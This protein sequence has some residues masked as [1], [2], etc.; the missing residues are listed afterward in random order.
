MSL[1][2]TEAEY[3]VLSFVLFMAF[4]FALFFFFFF[5]LL[6]R[7]ANTVCLL[8]KTLSRIFLRLA[9]TFS[10]RS[11]SSNRGVLWRF[12]FFSFF[13]FLG[14]STKQCETCLVY[15]WSKRLDGACINV[16]V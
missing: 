11:C 5:V 9:F 14:I 12:S 16:D 15:L 3:V 1:Y 8:A 4:L 7:L 2:A 13:S 6:F 10:R